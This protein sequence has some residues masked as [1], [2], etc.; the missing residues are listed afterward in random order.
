[1]KKTIVIVGILFFIIL[2]IIMS[3]T[4]TEVL[5]NNKEAKQSLSNFT[6]MPLPTNTIIASSLWQVT[7]AGN[8]NN[9]V[10]QLTI[11]LQS[12]LL[13]TQL[14]QYYDSYFDHKNGFYLKNI[15]STTTKNIYLLTIIDWS[16]FH[17]AILDYRCW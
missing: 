3:L 5:T 9:C 10:P 14:K 16:K 7:G 6:L 12:S 15:E 4:I 2:L 17:E 11:S 1:M 8:G 13:K